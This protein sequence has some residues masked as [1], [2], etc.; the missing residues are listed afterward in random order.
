MRSDPVSL[1]ISVVLGWMYYFDGRFQE[2]IEQAKRTIELDRTF[3]YGYVLLARSYT[4]TAEYDLALQACDRADSVERLGAPPRDSAAVVDAAR[5]CVYAA[6]GNHDRALLMAG[7]LERRSAQEHIPVHYIA[8]IYSL[9]GDIDRAIS[10]L[11]QGITRV[12][13]GVLY[14]QVYPPLAAVRRDAR[15]SALLRQLGIRPSQ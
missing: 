2:A 9:S 14:L 3:L 5:A 11:E 7:E 6:R 15:Y 8:S 13:P 12:D 4:E 1:P 10:T